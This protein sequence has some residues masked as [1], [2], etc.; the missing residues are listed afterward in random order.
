MNAMRKIIYLWLL[1]VCCA[2][3][4]VSFAD[5]CA[6]TNINNLIAWEPTELAN[7]TTLRP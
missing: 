2:V 1:A 3:P 5:K 6:G 4:T 7:G